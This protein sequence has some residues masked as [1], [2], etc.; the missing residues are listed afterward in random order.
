M[1]DNP[2][3]TIPLKLKG[4]I[5]Y[6][7]ASK[8]TQEDVQNL[9]QIHL[10]GTERWEPSPEEL[11]LPT[12]TV[13]AFTSNVPKLDLEKWRQDALVQFASYATHHWSWKTQTCMR[14]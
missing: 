3:V 7:P 6:F 8:P 12:R 1:A 10:M 4:I 2:K 13:S 9:E 11:L 14:G 5:S